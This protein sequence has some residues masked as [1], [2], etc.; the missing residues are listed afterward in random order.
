[1]RTLALLLAALLAVPTAAQSTAEYTLT[2][3]STWSPSTHPDGFPPNPHYSPLIGASHAS[4]SHLW[5]VGGTAS[6]GIERM[7]ETGST[8]RL[9]DEIAGLDNAG[10]IGWLLSGGS[11]G[12]SPGDASMLVTVSESHPAVSIVTMLAPSP[13]W[14]VGTDGLLLF[15]NGAWRQEVVVDLHV[16]DAGTDSGPG[17]TSPDADTQPREPIAR[18][19]APPFVVGGTLTPVGTYTFTLQR[20]VSEA[21][22]PDVRAAALSAPRPNPAAGAARLTLDVPA[23]GDVSVR[24]VDVLGR[25]VQTLH[26]GTTA[27]G[28]LPLIVDTSALA[29]G[30]YTVVARIGD[31]V[32]TRRVTA[33]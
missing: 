15:E 4:G 23:A 20:T 5:Q 25:T 33:L 12:D 14:F 21:G 31:R 32:L 26:R 30:T 6:E 11:I 29:A 13:D 7:A 18:I 10:E 19:E 9:R 8:S 22:G 28:A 16:Y 1:M 2:F 17:Y 3:E 27:A 24:V